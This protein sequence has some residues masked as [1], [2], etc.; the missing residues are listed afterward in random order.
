MLQRTLPLPRPVEPASLY[1]IARG[2][3][4]P[5]CRLAGSTLWRATR[6]LGGPATLQA[7]LLPD[8]VEATAWG[9][10]AEHVLDALPQLLGLADDLSGFEPHHEVVAKIWHD[11]SGLRLPRT[12]GVSEAL[13]AI[14]LEQ[15]VTTFEAHRS[16]RQ[17]VERWGEPAPGPAGLMLPVD[18]EVLAGIAYYELHVIGIEKARADTIRRVAAQARSLDALIDLDASAARRRIEQIPGVGPWSSAETALVALGDAD[19]VPVGDVHLPGD[20]TYALT[21]EAVHDDAAMLAALEPYEGH[22]G[23]VVRLLMAAGIHAPRRAPR[24]APR[25]I[26]QA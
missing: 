22:R 23:R 25:D 5:T 15:R 12:L 9:D 14:V 13:I 6:S 21:G 10:G 4:D 20:V 24:Y 17:L 7:E 18:P 3:L 26:R 11:R 19:A 1:G 2:P 8:R 16:Q